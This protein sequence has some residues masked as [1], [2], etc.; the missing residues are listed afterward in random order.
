MSAVRG[1]PFVPLSSS[2]TEL[3]ARS[4]EWAECSAVQ[5]AAAL[6]SIGRMATKRS[7]A[8]QQRDSGTSD[9]A[10][11]DPDGFEKTKKKKKRKKKEPLCH[12]GPRRQTHTKTDLRE[13]ITHE[14]KLMEASN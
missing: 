7:S 6:R 2:A 8:A 4:S 13:A 14:G 10:K 5:H 11:H 12:G 9:K 1:F 3:P